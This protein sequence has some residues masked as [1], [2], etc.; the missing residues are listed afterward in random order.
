MQLYAKSLH[1]SSDWWDAVDDDSLDWACCSLYCFN[2]KADKS[3]LL[4]AQIL[5]F[6]VEIKCY[7]GCQL[8]SL[9]NTSRFYQFINCCYG[10]NLCGHFPELSLR[11]RKVLFYLAT[12]NS[13]N[14]FTFSPSFKSMQIRL[15]IFSKIRQQKFER[16]IIVIRNAYLRLAKV[17]CDWIER[18]CIWY[19]VKKHKY[20]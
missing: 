6:C 8:F 3:R 17:E 4:F 5:K 7:K 20:T 18:A 15:S 11:Y 9:K 10:N 13:L 19:D 16:K 12:H 1:N 2:D 14:W